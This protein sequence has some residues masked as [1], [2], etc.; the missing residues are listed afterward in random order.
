MLFRSVNVDDSVDA[1][2]HIAVLVAFQ[3]KDESIPKKGELSINQLSW[4]NLNNIKNDTSSF[5][6]WSEIILKGLYSGKINLPDMEN[7]FGG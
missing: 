1:E 6:L 4:L 2:H 3:H 5:D 7:G